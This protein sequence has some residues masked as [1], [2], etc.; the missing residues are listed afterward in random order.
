MN[1]PLSLGIYYRFIVIHRALRKRHNVAALWRQ[2]A[3]A[4]SFVARLAQTHAHLAVSVELTCR[5][6]AAADTAETTVEL[7]SAELLALASSCLSRAL[8]IRPD[9][10]LL[11]YDL[12]LNHYHRALKYSTAANCDAPQRRQHFERAFSAAR[13]TLQLNQTRWQNWNLLGIIS[14]S[15]DIDNAALAQHAFIKAVQLNRTAAVAWTNLG[16]LYAARA[17]DVR[18]ANR[19]FGQAQQAQTDYVPGWTGQACLAERLGQP[20]EAI[21]LFQHATRL[22]HTGEGALGFVHWI[23]MALQDMAEQRAGRTAVTVE[24][25]VRYVCERMFGPTEALDAIEWYLRAEDEV[26]V[27]TCC[28]AGYLYYGQS[29]WTQAVRCFERA[30]KLAA[31]DAVRDKM[32]FNLGSSLLRAARPA[33]AQNAF[34]AVTSATFETA[35]GLAVAHQLD[36]QFEEAYGVYESAL[37]ILAQTDMQ[38]SQTLVAMSAIVYAF[39]GERDAKSLLFHW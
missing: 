7:H 34:H 32:L 21:D 2:L 36:G 15:A 8:K 11:W 33:D 4:L 19:A 28:F 16:V 23:C 6:D 20:S 12:A 17:N 10:S 39:Q 26:S 9:D 30:V 27:S 38:R 3:S 29:L 18:L 37:Q 5:P 35:I 22:Q 14:A 25:H 13:Y 31:D 1:Y 24:P